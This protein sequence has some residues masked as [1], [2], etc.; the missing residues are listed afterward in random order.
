MNQNRNNHMMGNLDMPLLC[1]ALYSR[2]FTHFICLFCLICYILTS[3]VWDPCFNR[4]DLVG[5]T[6]LYILSNVCLERAPCITRRY[7]CQHHE[8]L[9]E[10]NEDVGT[11]EQYLTARSVN[12]LRW[13]VPRK[14]SYLKVSRSS[15]VNLIDIHTSTPVNGTDNA[16]TFIWLFVCQQH[17]NKT[18]IFGTALARLLPA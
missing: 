11:T 7:L 3:Y 9:S 1:H 17:Y 15:L 12:R 13:K 4:Y 10:I 8:L 16:F 14:L 6:L 18:F 2:M 5:E